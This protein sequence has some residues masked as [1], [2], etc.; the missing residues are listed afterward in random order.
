MFELPFW[1]GLLIW[2]MLPET[3]TPLIEIA[4]IPIDFKGIVLVAVACFYLL[5]T[6]NRSNANH[7]LYRL[8][9]L[10]MQQFQ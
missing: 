3:K 6:I 4:L 8:S 2:S 1:L 7:N 9:C 5:Q 10:V